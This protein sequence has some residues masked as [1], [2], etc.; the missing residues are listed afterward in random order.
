MD[1]VLRL[2]AIYLVFTGKFLASSGHAI[3]IWWCKQVKIKP[4]FTYYIDSLSTS[5]SYLTFFNYSKIFLKNM[6][7]KINYYS[8]NLAW[9]VFFKTWTFTN[10]YTNVAGMSPCHIRGK[11]PEQELTK[12][13][14]PTTHASMIIGPQSYPVKIIF[15]I[16]FSISIYLIECNL[17]FYADLFCACIPAVQSYLQVV[18]TINMVLRILKK[19]P[20]SWQWF[21]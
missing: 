18:I 3:K 14:I 1:E 5:F 17:F 21:I 13:A 12:L 20:C 7:M 11:S 15:S 8:L 4:E 2:L 9:S 10:K 19:I 6:W 16:I